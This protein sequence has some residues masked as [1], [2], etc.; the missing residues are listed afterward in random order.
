MLAGDSKQPAMLNGAW[1][2]LA[3]ILKTTDAIEILSRS[4]LVVAMVNVAS[5]VAVADWLLPLMTQAK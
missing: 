3:A 2:E 4:S 5:D 1:R